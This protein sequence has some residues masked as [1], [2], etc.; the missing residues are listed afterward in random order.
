MTYKMKRG[1]APKFK[2]LGSSPAKQKNIHKENFDK[3]Q[4]Q[5]EKGR[6]F[7]KN[8]KTKGDLATTKMETDWNLENKKAQNQKLTKVTKKTEVS[9]V[10]QLTNLTKKYVPKVLKQLGKRLGPVG[11]AIT[12]T[13]IAMT[14]PKATKASQEGLK[15]EAK[16]RSKGKATDLFTGPKY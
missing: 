11:A 16:K 12:A 6:Q 4:A 2:E 5:R 13:E 1:T 10:K 14:I 15:K 9:K 8:L 7:V 3:F